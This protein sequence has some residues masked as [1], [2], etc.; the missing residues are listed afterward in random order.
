MSNRQPDI[1]IH[2]ELDEEQLPENI[3]WRSS[4]EP[5]GKFMDCKGMLLSFFDRES[6]DT[7]R[8][9]LWTKDMQI[10]EM[11]RFFFHT[12]RSMADTYKKSTSNTQLAEEM[13]S[14]VDHFAKSTGLISNE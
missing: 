9:D 14:F 13:Q 5:E 7:F 3:K 2:V 12:L 1:A 6:R 8:I 4:Q 11:D 10:M